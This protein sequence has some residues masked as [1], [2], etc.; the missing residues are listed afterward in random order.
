MKAA[1]ASVGAAALASACCLGPVLLAGVGA[2]ALGAATVR[3]EPLRPAFL[4]I[5]AVLL[6]FAFYGVYRRT[7]TCD[8]DGSCRTPSR[9]IARLV[10]WVVAALVGLLVAFPYYVGF[11]P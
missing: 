7:R 1:W 4:A 6:A 10:V 2:G 8:A 9:P 11:L 5:T 3:L